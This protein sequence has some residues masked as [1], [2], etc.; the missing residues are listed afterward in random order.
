MP[1]RIA[2]IHLSDLHF[3]TGQSEW[4]QNVVVQDMLNDL[5]RRVPSWPTM[6]FAVI[7]GDLAF[8]GDSHE[9]RLVGEFLDAFRAQLGLDRERLFM[10]PGNHDVIRSVQKTCHAGARALLTTPQEVDRFL[11]DPPERQ[12]LFERQKNFRDFDGS[13]HPGGNRTLTPDALGYVGTLDVD[14]FGIAVVGLNSAWLC[15]GDDD[16]GHILVGERQALDSLQI[17][18]GRQDNLVIGLIHHPMSWLC[19]FDQTP[20]R[21]RFVRRC[22][23]MHRG[24][25]HDPRVSLVQYLSGET[26]V[27][28]GAGPTYSGRQFKNSYSVVILD[29]S[30]SAATV[31]SYGYV[32]G[33]FQEEPPQQ[34]PFRLKGP[35][36]GTDADL[37]SGI[38]AIA[39][40]FVA[41]DYLAALVWEL[42]TE[43]PIPLPDG[44]I[45]FGAPALLDQAEQGYA[46][47]AMKFLQLRNLLRVNS[48]NGLSHCIA[49]HRD[50]IA[51][52]TT[53][54]T[55]LV[56]RSPAF[57]TLLA[58]QNEQARNLRGVGESHNVHTSHTCQLMVHLERDGAWDELELISRRYIN[59]TDAGVST[60]ARRM[61]G[62]CLIRYEEPAM[63]AEGSE[64]LESL[65]RSEAGGAADLLSALAVLC[66]REDF[67]RAK[68]LLMLG[69]T[70]CPEAIRE[71]RRLGHV[72]AMTT[73]DG[74]L[75]A[76]L[77]RL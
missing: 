4:S 12:A 62:R 1:D 18:N 71:L 24:H 40:V 6:Q 32:D 30:L 74:E 46:A 69:L 53:V 63:L 73:G 55:D 27:E 70:K 47:T 52:Y 14:G 37:A 75:K 29:L 58:Q 64:L 39:P 22:D 9:Y 51:A 21:A 23:F 45:C 67:A 60:Y 41:P 76:M 43:I 59:S 42:K 50:R 28:I 7:S 38:A 11:G 35:L 2:W 56:Q 16:F 44:T 3:K 5:A 49:R 48:N 19:D 8:S 54:L 68:S 20:F 10:V 57:G 26:C 65:A 15:G 66:G 17:L 33:Q 34:V 13:F 61:L 77:T 25:L 31:Y 72:I 36:P